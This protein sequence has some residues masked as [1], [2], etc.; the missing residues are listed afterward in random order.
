[1]SSGFALAHP[2]PNGHWH[3]LGTSFTSM[4][5]TVC[6]WTFGFVLLTLGDL[7]GGRGR[8]PGLLGRGLLDRLVD[9][10][11]TLA[12]GLLGLGLF[13]LGLEPAHDALGPD[14]RAILA[15]DDELRWVARRL[16]SQPAMLRELRQ[17]REPV[18]HGAPAG[19][20]PLLDDGID[21]LGHPVDDRAG[22]ESPSEEHHG[23]G[24]EIHHRV[25]HGLLGIGRFAHAGGT[26]H[27]GL[28]ELE[29]TR[30][31]RQDVLRI[32][33]GKTGKPEESAEP[34]VRAIGKF[35][36]PWERCRIA[37]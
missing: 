3:W 20:Q 10:H 7:L 17:P 4:S 26:H 35:T 32:R 34:V 33:F 8:H 21:A 18:L 31:D 36:L 16:V 27:S 11:R 2:W 25:H 1:M 23:D 6:A 22:G 24:E 29:D 15:E 30:H 28:D 12:R 9:G 37:R 13:H 14:R 5:P 19:D